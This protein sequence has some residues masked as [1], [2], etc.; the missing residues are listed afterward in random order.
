MLLH[1]HHVHQD[2]ITRRLLSTMTITQF[3]GFLIALYAVEANI[4]Y[5]RAP[6]LAQ[7]VLQDLC[8]MEKAL[9]GVGPAQL[10]LSPT[11]GSARLVSLARTLQIVVVRNV[12]L[13]LKAPM[14]PPRVV[15]SAFLVNLADTLQ[16]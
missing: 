9:L 16:V 8:L 11:M 14:L 15:R 6:P 12:L 4:P 1:V 13:V 3:L 2:L 7:L 5:Q 10:V